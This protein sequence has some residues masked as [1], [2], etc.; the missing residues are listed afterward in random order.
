MSVLFYLS[1]LLCTE[2]SPPRPAPLEKEKKKEKKEEEVRVSVLSVLW[3]K[4]N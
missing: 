4:D 2:G 3:L 1:H